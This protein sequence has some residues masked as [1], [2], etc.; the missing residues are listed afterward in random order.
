MDISLTQSDY[1]RFRAFLLEK[2]GLD[3]AEDKRQI[4]ARGLAEVLQTIDCTSLDALYALL[5]SH[6]VTSQIWDQVVSVLTVGETYFFRNTSHFDCLA[7]HIL[8]G[9]MAD[10]EHSSRRIRI[11]SA[12]C[13]T[14]EEPYS[15][16]MCAKPRRA[17]T[18]R[19]PFA[20][21]ICAFKTLTSAWSANST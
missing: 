14:G 11:W 19:G 10:R 2:I 16:A 17:R 20:V 8:P 4:L 15:V 12:G 7:K 9:I 13:A 3:F 18:G 5:Q 21:S 1:E 6:S